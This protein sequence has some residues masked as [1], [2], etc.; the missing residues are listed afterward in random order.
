MDELERR[1]S[2][3][4]TLTISLRANL[5]G[6]GVK[7]DGGPSSRD[8][9]GQRGTFAHFSNLR[10]AIEAIPRLVQNERERIAGESVNA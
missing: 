1:L 4:A 9:L 2:A 8:P 7:V 5:E 3:P 10:E 6:V